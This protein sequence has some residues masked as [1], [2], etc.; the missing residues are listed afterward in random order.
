[1]SFRTMHDD[2]LDPDKHLWPDEEPEILEVPFEGS[3]AAKW[4]LS[5]FYEED[6]KLLRSIWVTEGQSFVADW[7][8][9]KEI[10]YCHVERIN[11]KTTIIAK[12]FIDELPEIADTCLWQAFGGNDKCESGWDGLA[13]IHGLDCDKDHDRLCSLFEELEERLSSYYSE[14]HESV[15]SLESEATWEDFINAIDKAEST[16]MREAEECYQ[17]LVEVC[18][19]VITDE[20]GVKLDK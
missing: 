19:V 15:E 12:A 18:R 3:Y 7:G 6:E 17:Q 5:D 13:K 10:N 8:C 20:W 2:Y 16:A 14:E 11:G 4:A 9:K 1:M